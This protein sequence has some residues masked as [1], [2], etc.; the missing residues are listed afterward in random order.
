VSK[1]S[2][3]GPDPARRGAPARSC[4]RAPRLKRGRRLG[5]H[6][7]PPA[8]GRNVKFPH[9]QREKSKNPLLAG[10]T[11][12][13]FIQGTPTP[14]WLITFVNPCSE[15]SLFKADLPD[16]PPPGFASAFVTVAEGVTRSCTV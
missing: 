6:P 4:Q 10:E 5:K 3:A 9:D 12:K 7:A 8:P 13:H 11:K 1:G 15:P 14:D 2:A 16:E